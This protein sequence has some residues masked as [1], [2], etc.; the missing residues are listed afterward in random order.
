MFL[1]WKE[2][3]YA[4]LRYVLIIGIITLITALILSIS[5]LANGLA[6]D[7]A[8]AIK[9]IPAEAYVVEAADKHQLER[10]QLA[11]ADIEAIQRGSLLGMQMIEI[12][13]DGEPLNVSLFA[14]DQVSKFMPESNGVSKLEPYEVLADPSLKQQGI[15]IG[16]S[17]TYNETT[18]TVKGFTKQR[19]SYG[20]TPALI[21]GLD[22]WQSVFD[23][24]QAV[25]FSTK[26]S[27][28]LP[29]SVD[30]VQKEDI[31][32]NVPGYSAEQGSLT[33]M[34]TFLLIISAIVLATFFY[35][36]T[37]QKLHQYGVLKAIGTK[38]RILLSALFAQISMLSVVGIAAGVALTYGL[39][40]IIPGGV[41]FEL[42]IGMILFN[43][44]LILLMAWI[45][46]LLSFRSISSV[47]PLEAIGSVK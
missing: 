23:T 38:V 12:K 14:F 22:T 1:A 42:S 40:L 13:Q 37:L 46:S 15:N 5:G 4:K 28:D 34:V 27:K 31:L 9:S 6:V 30:A 17:F 3:R 24:Y 11:K 29:A 32:A 33:M 41:P 26:A 47:D 16:D 18:W 10:S 19:Y 2:M 45:G 43:S 35:V 39:T 25:L 8:S 21:T 44:G 36:M 20:H 7:N